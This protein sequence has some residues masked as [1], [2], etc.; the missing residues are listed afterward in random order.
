M[1][2]TTM[3]NFI[4]N[5][6]LAVFILLCV[7][8]ASYKIYIDILKPY[9]QRKLNNS[10]ENQDNLQDNIAKGY[11]E[12]VKENTQQLKESRE[13]NTKVIGQLEIINETNRKLS[14]TNKRLVETYDKR[15]SIVENATD[16]ISKTVEK[17]NTKVDMI[18]K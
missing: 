15:L 3:G 13:S 1:N 10:V 14:E 12:I 7:G 2:L 8:W 17:I 11:F 4:N 9:M 18:L 6:G 16:D 5:N